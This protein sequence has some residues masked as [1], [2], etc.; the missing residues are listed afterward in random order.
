MSLPIGSLVNN[1]TGDI[2]YMHL[3]LNKHPIVDN[4]EMNRSFN[5]GCMTKLMDY[6]PRTLQDIVIRSQEFKNENG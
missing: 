3:H 5:V 6:T 2:I 4:S 1:L